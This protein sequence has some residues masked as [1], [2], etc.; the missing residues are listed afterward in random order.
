MAQIV[1]EPR[2]HI[3]KRADISSKKAWAIRIIAI[4]A[5]LVI[6]ALITMICT[7]DNPISIF[8]TICKGAF[9][10]QRKSWITLQYVAILLIIS[11]LCR[12]LYN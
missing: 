4:L 9:G 8:T 5:A 3:V 12:R 11:L 7:G 2:F 6:C 1:K 10:T